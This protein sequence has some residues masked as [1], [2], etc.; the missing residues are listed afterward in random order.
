MKGR[1][2]LIGFILT[3]FV[4]WGQTEKPYI[5]VIGSAESEINPNIIV[6]SIRLKEYDENKVKVTLDKIEKR[7]S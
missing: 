2:L 7:F 1:L 3:N 5:E 6:I 4:S